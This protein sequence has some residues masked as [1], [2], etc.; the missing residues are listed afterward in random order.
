MRGF[1][2]ALEGDFRPGDS[3]ELNCL[4][5]RFCFCPVVRPFACCVRW[6]AFWGLSC[7][8]PGWLTRA[9]AAGLLAIMAGQPDGALARPAAPVP[10]LQFVW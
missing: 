8:P 9:C 5:G 6:A 10:L 4:S 7:Q 3:T 2:A 1:E